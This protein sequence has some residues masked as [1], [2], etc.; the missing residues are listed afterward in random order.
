MKV[1]KIKT[2]LKNLKGKI[3]CQKIYYL[4][5]IEVMREF[6]ILIKVNTIKNM[7]KNKKNLMRF[8]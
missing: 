6:E 5:K 7:L 1:M 2:R 8:F 4:I 3:F